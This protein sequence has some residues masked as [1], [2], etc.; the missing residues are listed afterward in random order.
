[1]K[2]EEADEACRKT[3]SDPS[4]VEE[5]DEGWANATSDPYMCDGNGYYLAD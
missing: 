3:T 5:D 4:S 2:V 1:M